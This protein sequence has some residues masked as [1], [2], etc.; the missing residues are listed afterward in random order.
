MSGFAGVCFATS[1]ISHIN[2]CKFTKLI[3]N[4]QK[5]VQKSTVFNYLTE[6]DALKG[7]WWESK[8]CL[9]QHPRPSHLVKI[10]KSI[11]IC[12]LH[13]SVDTFV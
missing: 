12:F 7:F 8:D 6:D 1:A 5:K 9:R 3:L 4:S 2:R 11:C 13:K 10:V